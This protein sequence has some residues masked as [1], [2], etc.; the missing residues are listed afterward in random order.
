MECTEYTEAHRAIDGSVFDDGYSWPLK[1]SGCPR[2]SRG[3][4]DR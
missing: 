1:I 4:S 2:D 3:L